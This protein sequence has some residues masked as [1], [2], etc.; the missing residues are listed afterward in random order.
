MIQDIVSSR[1][2]T[3][4]DCLGIED[5]QYLGEAET[6]EL[7]GLI[8]PFYKAN[9]KFNKICLDDNEPILLFHKIEE[10][11]IRE[12]EGFG[13]KKKE[14]EIYPV[15]AIVAISKELAG[16]LEN[17][18]VRVKYAFPKKVTN[19]DYQ[20]VR[21]S[22]NTVSPDHDKIIN[23]E[24]KRIDYSK[25]KCKFIVFEVDYTI[26]ALRCSSVCING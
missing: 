6:M 1:N 10:M 4:S 19:E 21:I 16:D 26:T 11:R 2:D 17:W 5:A 22:I 12:D 24:W 7:N 13:R 3:I 9:G 15:K 20:Y 25:H 14:E 8:Y 18:P 23:R